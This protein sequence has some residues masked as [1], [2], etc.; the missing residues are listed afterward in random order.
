MTRASDVFVQQIDILLLMHVN[1][2]RKKNDKHFSWDIFIFDEFIFLHLFHLVNKT[3]PYNTWNKDVE[4]KIE[5]VHFPYLYIRMSE[6]I[7]ELRYEIGFFE[8]HLEK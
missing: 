3:V 2:R 6:W 1:A 8:A 5:Y 7:F 4:W